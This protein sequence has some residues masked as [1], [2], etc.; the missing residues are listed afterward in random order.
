MLILPYGS[1]QNQVIHVALPR[2]FIL[3]V[4]WFGADTE[5]TAVIAF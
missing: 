1:P 5:R 3:E 2:Y 4:H